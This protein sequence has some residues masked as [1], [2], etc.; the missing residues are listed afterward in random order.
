MDPMRRYVDF[1]GKLTA[2]GSLRS[3]DDY[4]YLNM[5]NAHST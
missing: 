5:G 2:S 4:P 1:L 3:W